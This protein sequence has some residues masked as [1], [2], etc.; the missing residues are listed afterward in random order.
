METIMYLTSFKLCGW[1][2]LNFLY[3]KENFLNEQ[4]KSLIKKLYH[5]EKFQFQL[6]HRCN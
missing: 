4:L 6:Y 2:N 1:I 3:G 5:K